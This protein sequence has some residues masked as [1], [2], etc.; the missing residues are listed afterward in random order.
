MFLEKKEK[1]KKERVDLKVLKIE[2]YSILQKCMCLASF[3]KK[4][5]LTQET[6][7]N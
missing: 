2:Q 3:G 5:L 4:H 6:G 7:S 1:K